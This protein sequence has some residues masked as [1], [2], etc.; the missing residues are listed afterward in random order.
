MKL[1]IILSKPLNSEMILK[2]SLLKNIS[3]EIFTYNYAGLAV[4]RLEEQ[5][6]DHTLVTTLVRF[7][8]KLMVIS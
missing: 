6:K 2:L 3:N 8:V 5:I 7:P 1:I 4:D